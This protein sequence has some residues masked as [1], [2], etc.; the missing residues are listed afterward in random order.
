MGYGLPM[1]GRPLL[2]LTALLLLLAMPAAAAEEVRIGVLAYRGAERAASDWTPTF[3]ALGRPLPQYAFHVVPGDLAALTAE[4]AANR[5][6]FIITNP[7]HYVELETEYGAARIATVEIQGGPPP[8]VAV[9]A[10]IFTRAGQ[11]DLRGLHDLRG[12][13]LAAVAPDTFGFRQAWREM[14]KQGVDPF[15]DLAS[16][17]FLGFPVDGV[18]EAVRRGDADAGVVRAC[19]IE[20]MA[21]EGKVR[22]GEFRVIAGQTLPSP[23]C[24]VSTR[25]YPDWPFVKLSHT[26]EALAKQVA[27][28]L[29]AMPPAANGQAWTVPVDY[30]AVHDLYRALKIGPYAEL[31]QR[32]LLD[33]LWDNRHWLVLLGF[34]LVW[35][36]I[37]VLRVQYLVRK[38]TDELRAAN[39]DARSRREELEHAVRLSLVGE[40]AG[41]LAHEINQPLAAIAN[42]ARGCERRLQSGGD[43]AEV[44]HG[45][46]QI[47]A[48]A[49]RGG[50]IVR[51]MR[52]FV[53]KRPPSQH[54]LDPRIV[55][56][57]ALSLFAALA[58]RRGVVV[59]IEPFGP[60]PMIDA[61]QVQLE[62]VL[63]N[64]L[65]NAVDAVEGQAQ[66][67]VSVHAG[68]ADGVV[69]LSVADN[70]PGL[71]EAAMARLFE[72]FFTTKPQGL[73][74]GLSLSRSIV[75]AHGGRLWAENRP[76]GG[77]LFRVTLPIAK[78][79]A[80]V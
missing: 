16:L 61:D 30:H 13:R 7:G 48:Q 63:L 21:E 17:S 43:A 72:A 37:H 44:M 53:R 69:E 65:Q 47:A 1:L 45:V 79:T 25:L 52:D 39:E 78:E 8:A 55:I 26:S 46:R 6:D 58:A 38:R 74:L 33:L 36:V 77:A 42:Y 32:S 56:D 10:T 15:S 29:L 66:R 11:A 67:L 14:L 4:V 2:S 23:G 12:K 80:D 70:G 60:L 27:Q 22:P 3:D 49:E 24:Q 57:E 19:V 34:A 35:W 54:R 62:E 75:E 68:S 73:G 28:A 5:L 40:M 18:V 41:N 50:E 71:D 64:L 9:G 20:K 51:R 76:D 59:Q 31:R